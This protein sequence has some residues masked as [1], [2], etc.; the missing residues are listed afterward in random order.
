M[1]ETILS[2]HDNIYSFLSFKKA[3]FELHFDIHDW[4]IK[5]T[6]VFQDIPKQC[7]TENYLHTKYSY[8]YL[9]FLYPSFAFYPQKAYP[10]YFFSSPEFKVAQI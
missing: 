3:S 2:D 7:T 4:Q 10:L 6:K 9:Q 8:N 1:R 5:K